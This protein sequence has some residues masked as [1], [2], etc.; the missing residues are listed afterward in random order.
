MLASVEITGSAELERKLRLF[1]PAAIRAAAVSLY[2]SAQEIMTE[3]QDRYCPVD[4]GALRSSGR[5]EKPVVE[6]NNASVLLGYGSASVDYAVAVHEQN[7][8]YRNGKQYKYLET[9]L[10]A[11]TQDIVNNLV[12]DLNRAFPTLV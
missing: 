10:K 12:E 7:K 11:R 5:V 2:G 1:G 4:T 6:S 3:S 8:N 9:P